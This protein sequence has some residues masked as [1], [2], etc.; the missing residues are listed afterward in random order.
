M[1]EITAAR[2]NNLQARIELIL[3]FGAGQNGYGQSITS[4]NVLNDSNLIITADDLNNI[5][6]DMIRARIHQVG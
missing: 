6:A 5:Y 4:T 3:G 2:L 1:T